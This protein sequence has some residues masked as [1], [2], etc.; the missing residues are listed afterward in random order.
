[1]SKSKVGSRN[2][3]LWKLTYCKWGTT[4]R[5]LRSTSLVLC[6][7]SAEYAWPVWE[8]STYGK[9]LDPVLENNCRLKTGCLKPPTQA[10]FICSLA[11]PLL[12]LDGK[13]SGDLQFTS[14]KHHLLHGCQPPA[15]QLKSSVFFSHV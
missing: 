14:D 11:L 8:K 10:T 1:M 4:A 13:L 5:T 7:S 9:K 6:D 3:I 2:N 15:Q 12:I